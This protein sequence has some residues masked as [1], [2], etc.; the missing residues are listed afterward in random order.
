MPM[1][2]IKTFTGA[3]DGEGAGRATNAGA[4]GARAGT[5]TGTGFPLC[6]CAYCVTSMQLAKPSSIFEPSLAV[7]SAFFPRPPALDT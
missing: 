2:T 3:A 7:E 6:A 4:D 5:G 1:S